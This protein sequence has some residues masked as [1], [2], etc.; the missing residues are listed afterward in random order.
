M[1]Q[2]LPQL[3]FE[4]RPFGV[5]CVLLDASVDLLLG[6]SVIGYLDSP[7]GDVRGDLLSHALDLLGDS[8]H[9]AAGEPKDTYLVDLIV[10]KFNFLKDALELPYF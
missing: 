2:Q 9:A 5:G 7:L 4:L 1:L 8:L 3:L 10:F 6:M